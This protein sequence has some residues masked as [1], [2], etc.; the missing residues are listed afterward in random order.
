MADSIEYM[1]Q[2]ESVI[3]QYKQYDTVVTAVNRA[4]VEIYEG[5][6]YWNIGGEIYSKAT[7]DDMKEY[8]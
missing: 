8:A 2:T 6:P 3:K 1:L 4:N 7:I 5:E